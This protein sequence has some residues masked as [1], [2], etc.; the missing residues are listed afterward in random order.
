VVSIICE[1]ILIIG[2][3]HAYCLTLEGAEP[4]P[5]VTQQEEGEGGGSG[6]WRIYIKAK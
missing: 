3:I 1:A 5:I 2:T 4:C 6:Q